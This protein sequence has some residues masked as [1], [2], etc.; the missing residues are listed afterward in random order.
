[1]RLTSEL[2]MSISALLKMSERM[3]KVMLSQP[4]T[5][6]TASD[7]R[8]RFERDARPHLEVLRANARRLTSSDA[9]ADDLVQDTMVRAYR[10]YDRFEPGTNFKAWLFQIQRNVFV[11]RY[12]REQRERNA[13]TESTQTSIQDRCISQASIRDGLSQ[14]Q[15]VERPEVANAIREA[16]Q[17]L[18]DQARTIVIRADIDGWSYKEI[19]AEMDTPIGTVMSRLHRARKL[20]QSSLR[21]QAQEFGI[22]EASLEAA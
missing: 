16:L 12:R 10:Y 8:R 1:M 3:E 19:A 20:L 14:E 15:N 21:G 4:Q 5:Q 6:P 18:P 22:A 11:N 9:D 13:M 7:V 2:V 17:E